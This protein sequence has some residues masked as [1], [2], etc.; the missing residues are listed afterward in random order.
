MPAGEDGHLLFGLPVALLP[1]GGDPLL[2]CRE[3][4]LRI[5]V[6][7]NAAQCFPRG[8]IEGIACDCVAQLCGRVGGTTGLLVLEAERIAQQRAVARRAEKLL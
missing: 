4:F 8:G 7:K 6:G 5:V 3:G 1:C 2:E